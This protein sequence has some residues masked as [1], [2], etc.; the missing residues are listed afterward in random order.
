MIAPR[1]LPILLLVLA[2]SLTASQ[3]MLSQTNMAAFARDLAR[4]DANAEG[5]LASGQPEVS[6]EATEE[7][8]IV[9]A[10]LGFKFNNDLSSITLRVA[11]PLDKETGETEL[12]NL[13][14]LPGETE[15][16]LRFSHAKDIEEWLPS[17]N[18]T[19][20]CLNI[21]RLLA[22]QS[23]SPPE[24]V[25]DLLDGADTKTGKARF[26]AYRD[27]WNAF[28]L[29]V[30]NT[31][32]DRI[33]PPQWLEVQGRAVAKLCAEWNSGRV[34]DLLL[35]KVMQS[36]DE[37][38]Q[39]Q[40]QEQG[41][42]D[43]KAVE[44]PDLAR[45]SEPCTLENLLDR[46]QKKAQAAADLPDLDKVKETAGETKKQKEAIAQADFEAATQ[47]AKA[48]SSPDA[49]EVLLA[50][51]RLE[52]DRALREIQR[53]FDD[54]VSQ[55]EATIAN[56]ACE[57]AEKEE[58]AVYDA[59]TA[60]VVKEIDGR[61]GLD[62]PF[63]RKPP[64][65]TGNVQIQCTDI[66]AEKLLA[67]LRPEDRSTVFRELRAAAPSQLFFTG[68]AKVS[69]QDFKYI[70]DPLALNPD[71]QLVATKT[72]RE[73]NHAGRLGAS[74]LWRGALTSLGYTRNGEW[75]AKPSAQFCFPRGDGGGLVCTS[76]A[77]G[78]PTKESK[79]VYDL[80]FKY[81][82]S[83]AF[84]FQGQVFY[85]DKTDVLNPHLIAYF[86]PQA[87]RLRG[88]LDFSYLSNDPDGNDGF[89]LRLFVG[90]P[91]SLGD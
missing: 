62:I 39:N 88:G 32:S 1:I 44:N 41:Q 36:K 86:L 52:R 4:R 55:A 16:K 22:T 66:E 71:N 21:N 60:L 49:V 27:F 82:W 35:D 67:S 73:Y 68:E 77:S 38:M 31:Q 89:N 12:V 65:T 8:G 53:A 46:H 40:D 25:T 3:A 56:G 28:R 80:Q 13:S 91:F 64:Q 23:P 54:T 7:G 85:A 50:S 18:L 69:S 63:I 57:A 20:T 30:V 70:A 37:M 34:E 42:D 47:E 59:L 87:G 15:A 84:A 6:M 58:K 10:I 19:T 90:V 75:S 79:S 61:M 45:R 11:G 51:A 2:L 14:D 72:D 78:P 33:P 9:A 76:T 74:L 24:E 5:A 43:E 83:Q 48:L 29:H 26:E 81:A 17:A